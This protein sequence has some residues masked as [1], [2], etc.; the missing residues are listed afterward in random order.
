MVVKMAMAVVDLLQT[1]DNSLLTCI[2][3]L[4][5][6]TKIDPYAKFATNLGILLFNAIFAL[7]MPTNT[8]P[9]T[10]SQPTTHCHLLYPTSIGNPT[11]PQP[12]T[13]PMISLT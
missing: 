10:H 4:N 3:T 9:Q 1:E 13:S 2:S 11:M 8:T 12:T 6:Q 5:L 7:T